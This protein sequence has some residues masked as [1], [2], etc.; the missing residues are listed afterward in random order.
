MLYPLDYAE[1][2]ELWNKTQLCALVQ[3][4]TQLPLMCYKQVRERWNIDY[5]SGEEEDKIWGG[6]GRDLGRERSLIL[7]ATLHSAGAPFPRKL[8]LF[9]SV[10]LALT[11]QFCDV[12]LT[13]WYNVDEIH[14]MILFILSIKYFLT[15]V[16][17]KLIFQCIFVH[18]TMT[19]ITLSIK[20]C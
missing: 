5:I 8:F 14:A 11:Q 6:R 13:Y 9:L 16:M 2:V 19:R 15:I 12:R 1:E 20:L 10:Y 17:A 7:I 18:A 4:I 3:Q